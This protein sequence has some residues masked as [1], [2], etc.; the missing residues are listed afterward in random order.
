MNMVQPGSAT[1]NSP[2]PLALSSPSVA[3][4]VIGPCGAGHGYLG[5]YGAVL[6]D[7]DDALAGAAPLDPHVDRAAREV[8]DPGRHHLERLLGGTDEQLGRLN[9]GDAHG[10]PTR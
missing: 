1:V 6:A 5:A 7:G 10:A 2:V 4:T 8:L 9:R 3:V